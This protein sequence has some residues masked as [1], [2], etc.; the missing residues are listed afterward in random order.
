M[1][2]GCCGSDSA[3]VKT[4]TNK[5]APKT[6]ALKAAAP[7]TAPTSGA[8]EMKVK[9]ATVVADEPRA[10]KSRSASQ[11]LA[12]Y[13]AESF[14][15]ETFVMRT[16]ETDK[17]KSIGELQMIEIRRRQDI[18]HAEETMH[19]AINALWEPMSNSA[20][21]PPS[22]VLVLNDITL[23]DANDGSNTHPNAMDMN[24][25]FVGY[26]PSAK[27]EDTDEAK[28]GACL[29]PRA[30]RTTYLTK[31]S[32]NFDYMANP[33]CHTPSNWDLPQ[34]PGFTDVL[35]RGE[36]F[37]N[38]ACKPAGQM[39]DRERELANL[40]IKINSAD[41]IHDGTPDV[42]FNNPADCSKYTVILTKATYMLPNID[43][44]KITPEFIAGVEYQKGCLPGSPY[45]WPKSGTTDAEI[46]T[47]RITKPLI[48]LVFSI[49][50]QMRVSRITDPEI[51]HKLEDV[52]KEKMSHAILFERTKRTAGAKDD[53]TARVRS[54]LLYYPLPSNDGVLVTN[55]TV[56]CNTTIPK[57]VASVVQSFGSRG[58]AEVSETAFRTRKF[59]LTQPQVL[60]R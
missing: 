53:S 55:F 20:K 29:S 26:R 17:V 36:C 9:T 40:V 51:L 48:P 56:V 46:R 19:A 3:Q 52:D 31:I 10:A 35:S 43:P 30:N 4:A 32:P 5:P 8:V 49:V 33:K 59:L 39:T 6:S 28:D 23:A 24:G 2:C 14:A 57:I 54:V 18:E 42:D 1:P 34:L 45:L 21:R 12:F 58:A 44:G 37:M 11:D 7:S 41:A 60:K 25:D 47:F 27:Y 13:D 16:L 15:N 22:P 38:F 50:I